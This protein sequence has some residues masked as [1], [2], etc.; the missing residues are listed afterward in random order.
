MGRSDFGLFLPVKEAQISFGTTNK[1]LVST[2][3]IVLRTIDLLLLWDRQNIRGPTAPI[4]IKTSEFLS[5]L[6]ISY[7]V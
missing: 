5:M 1:T 7:H 2:V 4:A 6:S 3:S